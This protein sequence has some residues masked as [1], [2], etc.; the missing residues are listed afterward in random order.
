MFADH[1]LPVMLCQESNPWEAPR[2]VSNGKLSQMEPEWDSFAKAGWRAETEQETWVG[3]D[4][5]LVLDMEGLPPNLYRVG[6]KLQ[7]NLVASWR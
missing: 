2:H 7:G 1:G 6:P 5:V 4:A 3:T